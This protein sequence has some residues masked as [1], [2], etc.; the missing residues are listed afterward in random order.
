MWEDLKAAFTNNFVGAMQRLGNKVDLSQIK[1]GHNETLQ[2][3]VYYFFD[4]KATVVEIFELEIIDR[5][6]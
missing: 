1:Q 2:S 6:Q 5:F 3:Y 4:K